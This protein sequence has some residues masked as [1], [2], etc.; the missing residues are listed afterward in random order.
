MAGKTKKDELFTV[1]EVVL[2][3][4]LTCVAN[5]IIFFFV[6]TDNKNKNLVEIDNDAISEIIESYNY[7]KDNYYD[8]INESDLIN[9]AIKGMTEALGDD[10]STFIEE[11]DSDTYD[12][13]LKGEYIGV[14]IQ[15]SQ[16]VN[17]SDII[18]TTVFENSP[19]SEA[20]LMFGDI[21][22]SI[23]G[24]NVDKMN[25]STMGE[26][27]KNGDV[28]DFEIIVNRNGEEK[29]FNVSRGTITIDSVVSQMINND[30]KK[31]GYINMNVFA[32]NTDE[33]FKK[34][35]KQLEKDGM[36][37]LIIDVRGN[38]GG[39]LSTVTNIISEFL[40]S[41]KVIYQ[42]SGKTTTVVKSKGRETKKYKIVLLADSTSASASEVL[43]AALKESYGAIIVGKTTFGKGTVQEMQTIPS[44]G[45][46][47]KITTKKW[48]T[49]LGNWINKVGITP[50]YD[51]TLSDEYYINPTIENDNQLQ[52]ALKLL[53]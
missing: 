53:K 13:L 39:H 48:L 43:L 42:T 16:R 8:E 50:D 34:H 12:I 20:G 36:E 18:I 38:T 10:Y 17:S 11:D 29:K 33:Q 21:I 51:V 31:V 22:K 37:S 35:L 26:Y 15:I 14:G 5:T 2:L 23:N 19:A 47:Y 27:I 41:S 44:T 46:N 52:E 30:E 9:G 7:I 4:V 1:K 45:E 24:I 6:N 25:T 32:L 3:L 49:P 40:D 28:V